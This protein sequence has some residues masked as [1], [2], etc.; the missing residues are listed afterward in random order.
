M[1]QSESRSWNSH[2]SY[3]MIGILLPALLCVVAMSNANPPTKRTGVRAPGSAAT[4]TPL[5]NRGFKG[6]FSI[7]VECGYMLF[8][9][10]DYGRDKARKWPLILFLHGAGERGNDLEKVK[11]HGI[12]LVAEKNPDFPFIVVAPQCPADGWWSN[13]VLIAL[14]DDIQKRYQTDPDRVYLTGLSMGGFGTWTLA[15]EYPGRFAAIAPICGGGNALLAWRLRNIPIWAFHGA[16]DKVVPVALS[17]N[18]VKAVNASGGNARLTV[19]PNA[20]HNSWT[21][22][23]DTPDLYAWFL[24]QKR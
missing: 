16:K 2:F 4:T 22:T 11:I 5:D 10:R 23:Y 6:R 17:E 12:P 21:R 20:T 18:M 14:L 7:P 15:T 1:R 19:Y 8:L 24:A 9:P 3:F 13:N